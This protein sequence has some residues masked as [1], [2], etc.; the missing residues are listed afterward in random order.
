MAYPFHV[1]TG[2]L[3]RREDILWFE[4]DK[5]KQEFLHPLAIEG[6]CM[7]GLMDYQFR[8]TSRDA[9]EMD[10]EISSPEYK[11]SVRQEMVGQMKRI[12]CEK[13]LGYVQFYVNFVDEIRTDPKTGKKRLILEKYEKGDAA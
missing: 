2:L 12:L 13:G 3:G 7:E 10:A 8:Q 11:E 5:G 6:F 4:N 1:A 9:F